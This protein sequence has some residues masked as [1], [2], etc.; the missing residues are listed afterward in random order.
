[1]KAWTD[2]MNQ[3]IAEP[4]QIKVWAYPDKGAIAFENFNYN[5]DTREQVDSDW[6]KVFMS[7]VDADVIAAEEELM[8][9]RAFRA[10]FLA[11]LGEGPDDRE[12]TGIQ[13]IIVQKYV[14]PVVIEKG[15]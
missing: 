14:A 1:M 11:E 13:K 5:P 12:L 9:R 8:A 10:Y 15:I 4:D 7:E 3:A 2:L 6:T